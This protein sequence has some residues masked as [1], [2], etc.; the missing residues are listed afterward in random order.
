MSSLTGQQIKDSYQGLLK[1]ADSASGITNSFQSIQDGLG[2]DTGIKIKQNILN[3]PN[4]T[5]VSKLFVGDLGGTGYGAT[6]Q[7]PISNS[8]NM[9]WGQFFYDAGNVAYSALSYNVATVTSNSDTVSVSVYDTQYV[10][11][12]GMV[13]DTV[14]M[15]GISLTGLTST[16]VKTVD[17]PST[18]SFSGYGSGFYYFVYQIANSATPTVR[19][20]TGS[21]TGVAIAQQNY[22]MVTTFAGTATTFLKSSTVN[23]ST[24]LLSGMTS[25][26]ETFVSSDFNSMYSTGTLLGFGFALRAIK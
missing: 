5:S 16:G 10:D 18:L 15:S 23:G 2:N 20:G 25:F 4:I 8:Q 19:L 7:A 6:G 11:G 3:P 24:F 9:I 26:P 22:G 14:I 13:P 1:L 21:N 12:V 17:L